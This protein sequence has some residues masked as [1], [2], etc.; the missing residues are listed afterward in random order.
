MKRRRATGRAACPASV[1]VPSKGSSAGLSTHRVLNPA[2]SSRGRAGRGHRMRRGQ[3]CGESRD[4]PVGV[5]LHLPPGH[6]HHPQ[7]AGLKARDLQPVALERDSPGVPVPAIDFDDQVEVAPEEVDLVAEDPGFRLISL[8]PALAQQSQEPALCG[9]AG[10][11]GTSREVEPASGHPRLDAP[12][13]AR[14][15]PAAR[16][17]SRV[18]GISPPRQGAPVHPQA[19]AS[20]DRTRSWAGSSRGCRRGCG[21]PGGPCGRRSP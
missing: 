7:A 9:G 11:P 14:S 19:A 3:R 10:A 21:G 15:G 6:R 2:L 1:P 20:R 8:E 4:Y 5:A 13:S 16:P 12:G 18:C 17:R